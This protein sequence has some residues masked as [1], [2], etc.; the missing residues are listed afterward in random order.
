MK[1]TTYANSLYEV[2]KIKNCGADE[3]I[4][5]TKDIS[6]FGKL[7]T[8][9]FNELANTAKEL[10][11][12]V[13]C[14][15]D[16]LATENDFEQ[17]VE[18]F[19]KLKNFDA[20]RVQDSGVLNYCLDHTKYQIQ[21]IAETG[22]HNFKALKTWEDYIG[23]RLERLILSIEL[24][25][26]KIEKYCQNLKTPCELQVLGPILLFYTPR[27]LLSSLLPEDDDL[28]QK[29]V[30]T[31][32][33]ESE[34]SPHKGFPIIEN[35][36][37]TFM[38]NTRHFNL[39]REL[40]D[41]E[42]MGLAYACFDLYLDNAFDYL[43]LAVD[44]FN[45]KKTEQ[46]FKENYSFESIRGFYHVNKSDV[47]FKKL[48]NYRI[49]RKDDGY[50]GEVIEAVKPKYLAIMIK[51]DESL[52]LD[53]SL[54]FI[55]PE[56]LKLECKVYELTDT[57]LSQKSSL[58]KGQI[59]LMNYMGGVWVKSSVYKKKAQESDPAQLREGEIL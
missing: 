23:D 10:G 28:R 32:V 12:K 20:L 50:L 24:S 11:L 26:D 34:E 41:L 59:A 33:G 29:E 9:E 44:V 8:D 35:S 17:K 21:F 47:L 38:F 15:W 16:I 14:L 19:K 2:Q 27:N 43:D 18:S 55:T 51:S 37:G 31:S 45:G 53:D 42:K 22:N 40:K 48:K 3:V 5:G 56:G 1:F 58:A 25:C 49:Q 57:S 54:V 30:L 39:M 36:H 46:E 4:L 7:S 13:I 52:E 6:R